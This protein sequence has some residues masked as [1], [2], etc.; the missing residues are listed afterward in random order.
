[1]QPLLATAHREK[2]CCCSLV[3]QSWSCRMMFYPK[4]KSRSSQ[5]HTFCLHHLGLR[6]VEKESPS[7][8]SG[9]S[10]QGRDP[11]PPSVARVRSGWAGDPS[12]S[13][14][15]CEIRWC[16]SELCPDS[17]C[18]HQVRRQHTR[19]HCSSVPVVKAFPSI[20]LD[21]TVLVSLSAHRLLF[22]YNTLL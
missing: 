14:L 11:P 15:S 22:S 6:A 7:A 19:C 9:S 4:R 12:Q 16:Y 13:R 1:M 18:K 8:A 5:G 17:P 10:E 3:C 2:L 21:T 20:L